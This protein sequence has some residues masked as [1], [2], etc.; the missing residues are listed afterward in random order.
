MM[1]GMDSRDSQKDLRDRVRYQIAYEKDIKSLSN[2]KPVISKRASDIKDQVLEGR[3]K[4]QYNKAT[5]PFMKF[6]QP[7]DGRIQQGTFF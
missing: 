2:T 1:R 7:V 5:S 4:A 3:K 6:S